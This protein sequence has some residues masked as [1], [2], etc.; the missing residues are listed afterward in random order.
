MDDVSSEAYDH[1][2]KNLAIGVCQGKVVMLLII[3]SSLNLCLLSRM[4]GFK[5]GSLK[6]LYAWTLGKLMGIRMYSS[7]N[8][9]FNSLIT[10]SLR[11]PFKIHRP[12]GHKKK[13]CVFSTD[14]LS[15]FKHEESIQTNEDCGLNVRY[16]IF[17]R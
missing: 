11:R 12:P 7:N 10:K 9:N 16:P 8:Q 6:I 1:T 5:L 13:I 3:V 15:I 14:E 17:Y 2:Y 4:Q